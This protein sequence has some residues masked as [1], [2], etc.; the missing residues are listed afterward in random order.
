MRKRSLIALII[1]LSGYC[2]GGL[3][4]YA[5]ETAAYEG[6]QPAGHGIQIPETEEQAP[7]E[8]V[9]P[10]SQEPMAVTPAPSEEKQ[11][12]A[13]KEGNVTLDF[14][15]A[16]MQ[17]V[18]RVLA[19]KSGVNIVASKEVAGTVTIRLVDVPWEQ[20]LAV[21]LSTYGFAY[22]RDGNII[23]VSTMEALKTR[24]ENQK[25]LA[26]IEGVTSKVFNLQ[27]LDAADAKKMLEP[28]LSPQG[29]ISV[30]EITGQKGWEFG[31]AKAGESTE[32]EGKAARERRAARSR[33]LII[34]DTPTYLDRIEKVLKEID[35]KPSQVLIEARIMEVNRDTLKDLGIEYATGSRV[36]SHSQTRT[37]P[38]DLVNFG[39]TEYRRAVNS[40]LYSESDTGVFTPSN[41][42]PKAT[43][44]T[45]I[46]AGIEIL[47][48][49][50]FRTNMEVLIHALEED[51]RTNTLSAPRI[52]TLSGQEAVI[53]VGQKYPIIE[54]SVSGTSGT[55]TVTLAYYQ[56]I[57]I[58]L[59]VV[60]QITGD[61]KYINM[62]VHPVVS[63]RD[64]T[65][66]V[67]GTNAYPLLVTREAETQVL[68]E[69]GETIV[70]G[71]LLKD[72]KSQG[73][74]GIPI[75]S[76]IPLIGGLFT[77]RTTDVEKIDLLIFITARIVKPGELTEQEMAMVKK[78]MDAGEPNI[79][80]E[81]VEEKK[82]KTKP[83]G[84]TKAKN[85]GFLKKR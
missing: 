50:L 30:L 32:E 23:T 71:G 37:N 81:N 57:G 69:D 82:D 53:L 55:A 35:V 49:R 2:I 64:G 6:T 33:A 40:R 12:A 16:D 5:Q 38:D 31:A 1:V 46:N 26:D 63:A 80:P 76:D 48:K 27:F 79:V 73:K 60:P 19:Y 83:E 13:Q 29:K 59:Y 61:D 9:L 44:L 18:L 70:I 14:K 42:V 4:C 62:I 75:L 66:T 24:R 68:M 72:V 85:K 22:E 47:I 3:P 84:Y 28:Q 25:Q 39:R 58:Q 11:V 65:A 77:R 20:A 78:A 36:E 34:T 17:N 21:I 45:P 67:G 8:E 56:D 51:V 10:S 74:I 15:D 7:A 54:S 41:F 43:G 52:L